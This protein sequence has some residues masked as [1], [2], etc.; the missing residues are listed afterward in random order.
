[1]HSSTVF[2]LKP[3]NYHN[4]QTPY[5]A[6]VDSCDFSINLLVQK[7]PTAQ[8]QLLPIFTVC[9]L[10]S[11]YCITGVI[12]TSSSNCNYFNFVSVLYLVINVFPILLQYNRAS[13]LFLEKSLCLPM[14]GGMNIDLQNFLLAPTILSCEYNCVIHPDLSS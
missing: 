6:R 3:Q 14:T 8:S 9:A 4:Q 5:T 11:N 10:S 1:M 2:I 13:N 12:R 7:I